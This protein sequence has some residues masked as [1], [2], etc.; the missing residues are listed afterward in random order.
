MSAGFYKYEPDILYHG[1]NFVL[2]LHYELIAENKD[3]YTY[4]VDGWYWF[5]SRE[6]ALDFW[7]IEEDPDSNQESDTI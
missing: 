6:E 2:D 7:G 1:P 5:N 3:T 4:P